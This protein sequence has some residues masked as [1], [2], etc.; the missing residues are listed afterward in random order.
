MTPTLPD[1]TDFASRH[2]AP[3]SPGRPRGAGRFAPSPTSGLHLGNLRTALAAWLLARTSGR[4]FLVRIEDLDRARVSAAGDIA[5]RQLADLEFLGLDWDG[6]VVRQSERL[7]LYVDAVG[8]LPTYPCFCTRREIAAASTAPNDTEWRPYPGTCRDLS[9][10]DRHERARRRPPAIRLRS[11]THAATVTDL[12]RGRCTGPLDDLVLVRNDGTPA[13]NLAVVVDDGLQGVD[14]VVRARDL[15]PSTPRQAHLAGLLGLP[16][17]V[18]AHTGLVTG[19]DGQRLSKSAGALGLSDLTRRGADRGRIMAW[20][21][22]SL[23]LPVVDDPHELLDWPGTATALQP[24]THGSRVEPL[25]A[26][27]LSGP[28][29]WWS[30]A[31]LDVDAL[32][33]AS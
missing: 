2:L 18:W 4:D 22:T 19:P 30:D 16:E 9:P 29:G 11:R 1:V 33:P 32:R 5:S 14:Q 17:P 3:A 13:Y 27:P 31:V 8:G 10:T 20:L 25:D 21:C 12:A 26:G 6:P 24:P 23:G 15:W 28:V 7:D